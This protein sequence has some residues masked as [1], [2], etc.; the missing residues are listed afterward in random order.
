MLSTEKAM[1]LKASEE[2]SDVKLNDD[3]Q[4]SD[5]CVNGIFAVGGDIHNCEQLDQWICEDI[6]CEHKIST[7][8]SFLSSRSDIVIDTLSKKINKID[9]NM[10]SVTHHFRAKVMETQSFTTLNDLCTQINKEFKSR[11][12]VANG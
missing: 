4:Q 10:D 9:I 2:T 6:G 3:T 1:D 12:V 7:N 11:W 5:A 8:D